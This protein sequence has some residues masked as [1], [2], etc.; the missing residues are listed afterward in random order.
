MRLRGRQ[1]DPR[2]RH[3]AILARTAQLEMSLGMDSWRDTL[4]Q[5][6]DILDQMSREREQQRSAE[7]QLIDLMR[8]RLSHLEA[9]LHRR[10]DEYDQLQEKFCALRERCP[11]QG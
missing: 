9:V 10:E 7:D 5:M 3:A 4:T 11:D 6:N 1:E 2:E 8:R